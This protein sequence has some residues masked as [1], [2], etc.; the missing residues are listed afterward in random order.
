MARYAVEVGVQFA[1]QRRLGAGRHLEHL[2][3]D[4]HRRL[5]RQCHGVVR[6]GQAARDD[7]LHLA[8]AVA[9]GHEEHVLLLA[10]AVHATEHAYAGP[11]AGLVTY[12]PQLDVVARVIESDPDGWREACILLDDDLLGFLQHLCAV[13]LLLLARDDKLQLARRLLLRLLEEVGGLFQGRLG[14]RLPLRHVGGGVGALGC[15]GT[16]G[17][18][19][20]PSLADEILRLG[21]ALRVGVLERLEGRLLGA[22][23]GRVVEADVF[24][25]VDR[26]HDFASGTKPG[27]SEFDISV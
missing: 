4:F 11:P 1:V 24:V 23:L 8:I 19:I 13:L 20:A 9:Q 17:D 25:D 10:L 12:P 22:L 7:H 3:Q 15:I 5:A 14:S 18:V 6:P 26:G 27:G 21:W 2:A 16:H